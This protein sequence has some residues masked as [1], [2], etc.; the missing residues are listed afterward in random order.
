[1]EIFVKNLIKERESVFIPETGNRQKRTERLKL[2]E[3][4]SSKKK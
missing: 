2:P 4:G 3:N 1:M